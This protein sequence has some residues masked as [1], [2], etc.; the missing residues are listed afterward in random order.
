LSL[1]WS[2][3][4]TKAAAAAPNDAHQ[5]SNTQHDKTKTKTTSGTKISWL[6]GYL[7]VNSTTDPPDA[8]FLVVAS[9][10]A[11]AGFYAWFID[12]PPTQGVASDDKQPKNE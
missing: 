5:N 9:V 1:S 6:R 11:A 12:P 2:S 7:G 4:S 8:K 3:S 10:V